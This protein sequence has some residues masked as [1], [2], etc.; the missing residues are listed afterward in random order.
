VCTA[1]TVPGSRIR[2]YDLTNCDREPIHIPGSIFPH[3]ALLA[4]DP[5]TLRIV[6][7]GGDT[8]RLLDVPPAALIG[9]AVAR[10]LLDGHVARLK[11][12]LDHGRPLIRPMAAFSLPNGPE[13]LATDVIVHESSGLLVLEFEPRRLPDPEDPLAL[14]QSMM[15]H[16]QPAETIQA[17][18]NIIAAEVRTVS[19]FNR[20]MVYR[21]LPDGSGAVIAEA[22]DPGIES[23]LG[24]HYPPSD[25]PKQARALYL[26]NWSRLIPHAGYAPAPIHPTVN[27]ANGRPLD[28]SQSLLRSVSPVHRQYLA[29]MGVVATMSLSLVVRGTLW[30]LIACHHNA[31]RYLS[32][33]L[34]AVCEVFAEMIS[35]QIDTKIADEAFNERLNATNVHQE[36]VT[37]MS[38]E[39]DLA[40]GLIRFRPNLLDF[41]PAAGVGLWIDGRYTSFGSAP[42]AVEVEALVAWLNETA[43]DGIFHTDCLPLLYPP[44]ERYAHLASGILALSVSRHANDYVMWFRPE[45]ATT[46]TW[47]GN[48]NKPIVS[49]PDGE[50]LTPRASFAAWQQLVRLHAQPWLGA[51]VEAARQLRVSLLEVVL[52]RIDQISRE[53]ETA[54]LEQE[55]L[56]RELDLRVEQWQAAAHALTLETEHRTVLE[57]ELSLVLR[58]TVE[59]QEVE[60]LRIARELHDTLGQSLTLLQ[61]GL[62]SIG[63]SSPSSAD[64]QQR[65]TTLL[66]VAADAGV[67][68]NRLAWEIRPTA[69]DDLGIEKAIRNLLETWSERANI[70]FDVHLTLDDRRLSVAIETTLYR[71]LQEALTNV[72]RH[73][74]AKRVGVILG[75]ADQQVTMIIEDDG[76]GFGWDDAEPASPPGSRLGLLGIRERVALV[77]GSLEIESA[78]GKGTTLFI[79]IPL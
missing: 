66:K 46:V 34:R 25:I 63:R 21:F 73:A 77:G 24:L 59:S 49:G 52:R 1:V 48:P 69:L 28:L 2:D 70:Q 7:A 71:V 36:L 32:Y 14:V 19:G 20:V 67:E 5:A 38:Q 30:G 27:P 65:V 74:E 13:G 44:A 56:A 50:T 29:N 35:S 61:L 47:G 64:L 18:C 37:C 42:R 51:E 8:A 57:K 40:E 6:H 17:F 60:R 26:K 4:L 23:F 79:Q 43:H 33:R 3:G 76:R 16:V 53:R 11:D 78:L 75:V 12:L 39:P 31:P 68:V 15:G 41:I 9:E 55:K 45:V 58:R 22:H 54:R 72:V 10:V 62:E